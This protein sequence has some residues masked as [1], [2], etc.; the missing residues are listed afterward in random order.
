MKRL[1]I[2]SL[3]LTFCFA[4]TA[5]THNFYSESYSIY[6]QKV[7]EADADIISLLTSSGKFDNI[8]EA[9][10]I[11]STR[12]IPRKIDLN[13]RQP[14]SVPMYLSL[15]NMTAFVRIQQK[16]GRYRVT[17][18]QIVFISNT[19]TG[20]S[21]QGEQTTLETY[22]LKRDGSIKPMFFNSAAAILDEMLTSL[23]S[24]SEDLGD[25]W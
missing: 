17:V 18:D 13:G 20:L 8:N 21:Q 7:Y 9:D 10:G 11:V 16:E 25:N 19:T 14:G 23:F 3:L 12:L 6:W 4:M 1:V 22:A 5:Q 2:L 24:Q 15:S